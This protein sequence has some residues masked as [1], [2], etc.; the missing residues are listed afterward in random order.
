MFP[1]KSAANH[2]IEKIGSLGNNPHGTADGKCPPD[3]IFM[4]G[5]CVECCDNRQKRAQI[6]EKKAMEVTFVR[7]QLNLQTGV[8]EILR[9]KHNI[10]SQK[11]FI[12]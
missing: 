11:D 4:M 2:F 6:M 5:L 7:A 8:S 9:N 12:D 3:K 10:L 1:N